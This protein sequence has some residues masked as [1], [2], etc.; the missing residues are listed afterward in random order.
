MKMG[1][2]YT[3]FS[4]FKLKSKKAFKALNKYA[5][6]MRRDELERER[7]TEANTGYI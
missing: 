1:K 4:N 7:L 3:V 2:F 5:T 6:N